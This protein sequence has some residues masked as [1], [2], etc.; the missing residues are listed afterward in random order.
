MS[1]FVSWEKNRTF[2]SNDM[3]IIKREHTVVNVRIKNYQILTEQIKYFLTL[4]FRILQK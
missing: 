1:E 4:I 2:C 3:P